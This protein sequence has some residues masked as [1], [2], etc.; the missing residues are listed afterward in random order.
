MQKILIILLIFFY[1]HTSSISS[2]NN[3]FLSLKN[4]KVNVR[5]GPG[6]DYP[7]KYVYKKRF[8]PVKIIDSKENFR[9]IIDHKKNSGWIHISQLKK[10]NSLIVL[11]DKIIFSKNSKFSKPLLRLEKGRL[12]ILKKC[13]SNW[14]KI[15]S[16]NFTG[17]LQT[18]NSWG[19]NLK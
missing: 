18:Q 14:C 19:K 1:S 17:W 5:Y 11:E 13:M 4:N 3:Y 9:R 12:V 2:E 10:S 16:G 6:F 15:K 8:L 7:I